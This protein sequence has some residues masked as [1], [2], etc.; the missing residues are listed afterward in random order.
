MPATKKHST[1]RLILGDQLNPL[2]PWFDE[3]RDNVLYTLMEIRPENEY[4]THHIQKITGIFAAMRRFAGHLESEGH[5]VHYFRIT[6]PEN[7]HQFGG[8]LEMLAKKH[9]AERIEIQE[10]DEYRLDEVL[11]R[12]LEQTGLEWSATNSAHFYTDRSELADMFRNKKSF[13][14]ETFY[15]NMRKKH[16]VLME[17]DGTPVT[18]R[19]NYD[20]ENRNK[21]PKGHIPPPPLVFS[22]NTE[23]E[24]NDI[25]KA[26]LPH[27]GEIKP[28]AF[29]WPLNRKE[30]LE[31]L[32]HFLEYLLP[33]FGTFQDALSD[34]HPFVY[35]SRLS[36]AMNLK[37][38]GPAEVV[39]ATE[40]HWKAHPDSISLS[41][42][43]GFIRQILGWREYMRGIYWAKM[44]EFSQLNFFGHSRPL[45]DFYWTGDTPMRCVSKAIR[46]SLDY[47]YAHHI[48]RLMVTG[49]F[50][51]LAGIHP[52]EVDKW[53]LGIYV[54]AF[55]WV[56]IT[57]T[58]GMS[59]F[60]DGG[61]VG[62]K[63]Y[64][65][66]GSY[67]H[68]MGDHCRNCRYNPKESIGPKACP[69]NS[70]YWH[71][72]ERHREK[73]ENNPRMGMMYRVWDKMDGEK[74]M[75]LLNQASDF[76]AAL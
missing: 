62:T 22:H 64:V 7:L 42:A 44:P 31:V 36:F 28:K 69:F 15:R 76:I 1:I 66:S 75:A 30:A 45:P 67:I 74:R 33:H 20:A 61:I 19:W 72:L 65:S 48:Q 55:D 9:H 54:D 52:D 35:H 11:K 5:H 3:Q 6:D 4:V 12:A 53:Y 8:N 43:E 2:H 17:P 13:L 21:L 40:E 49:N 14:M 39:Q 73:L 37:M 32:R 56:E 29:P 18:G 23:A 57:N 24:Y 50:A 25:C 41:Q 71:F 38:I 26:Q 47:G 63:P 60:A 46:Q 16:N 27:F 34:E 58:R 10:P 68:K 51:L 70:L 59:Q